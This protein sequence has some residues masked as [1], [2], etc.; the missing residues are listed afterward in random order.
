MNWLFEPARAID[1]SFRDRARAHQQQLTKPAGSLGQLEVYAEMFAGWQST[2]HPHVEHIYIAVFA[3]D[4]GVCQQNISAFPQA[5]TTQMIANFLDGGAAISVLSRHLNAAFVVC[6]T[7]TVKPLPDHYIAHP[8][9]VDKHIAYGTADLSLHAA[10]TLVQLADALAAGCSVVDEA[11]SQYSSDQPL[12]L[13]IG[14]EM[15]IGNTTSASALCAAL[16]ELPSIDVVGPGTGVDARGLLHKQ[17][18]I[19]AALLLHKAILNEPCE[20]LRCLGGLEIAALVGSYI[21]CAQLGI[22]ILVDGFICTAAAL[23]AVKLNPSVRHWMLFS[24]CSAEP[25]HRIALNVLSAE[26]ILDL[27]LRLGE[28]SGAAIAVPIL[29]SALL[30]HNTMATFEQAGVNGG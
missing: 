12:Q 13:F 4:H 11:C 30:L 16:L 6:N 19:D 5:V 29:Q 7:G 26:P 23:M 3:G 2:I 20:I 1:L 17:S 18:V 24:H 21:R 10:M 27:G 22:P 14:G 9:W 15:G 8:Q 28:G 25:G